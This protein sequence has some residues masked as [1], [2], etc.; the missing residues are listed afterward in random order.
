MKARATGDKNK[1]KRMSMG[2]TGKQKE[3]AS[4]SK[5]EGSRLSPI[6]LEESDDDAKQ[7]RQAE[8]DG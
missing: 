6:K 2:K 5:G 3:Q 1:K 8:Y 7:A 4:P